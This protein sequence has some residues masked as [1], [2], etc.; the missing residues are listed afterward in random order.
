MHKARIRANNYYF[1][2]LFNE[3]GIR[4]E[5]EQYEKKLIFLLSDDYVSFCQNSNNE[6]ETQIMDD[7]DIIN[8]LNYAY[9]N[10]YKPIF[11][12]S[13]NKFLFD[14]IPEYQNHQILHILPAK[15]YKQAFSKLNDFVLVFTKEDINLDVGKLSNAILNIEQENIN[16]LC[17]NVIHILEKSDRVNINILN[18]NK[19]FDFEVYEKQLLELKD[20]LLTLWKEERCFK[21][22]NVITDLSFIGEHNNCQAGSKTITYAPNGKL[23]ICPAFYS[24]NKQDAIGDVFVGP[25]ENKNKHLFTLD[26]QPICNICDAYQ[27]TSCAFL[28]RNS[29]NEVNVPPSYQCKKG[30]IEREIS[31]QYNEESSPTKKGIEKLDYVDPIEIISNRTGPSIGFYK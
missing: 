31:R 30:L 9:N 23:Y 8:G 13:Q 15:F 18:L 3:Y 26:Y 29:T 20:Y 28:N 16:E 6:Y 11:V 5:A 7:K 24:K 14:M 10:F 2:R 21:E 4:K 27:C 25:I 19:N 1:A 12:H 22:L 17:K